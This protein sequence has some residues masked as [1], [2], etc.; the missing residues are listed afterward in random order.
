VAPLYK[1]LSASNGIIVPVGKPIELPAAVACRF[2]EEMRAFHA[3]PNAIKQDEIASRR[4]HA[5]SS[6]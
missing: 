3:E 5:A 4:P 1:L 6:L 2:V